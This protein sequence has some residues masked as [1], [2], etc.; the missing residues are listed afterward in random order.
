MISMTRHTGGASLCVGGES[1]GTEH[2][3]RGTHQIYNNSAWQARTEPQ[4]DRNRVTVIGDSWL[5]SVTEPD[6][7]VVIICWITAD[8]HCSW[9]ELVCRLLSFTIIYW[10]NW[11]IFRPGSRCVVF[12][13][14]VSRCGSAFQ[15]APDMWQPSARERSVASNSPH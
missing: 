13:V 15:P 12:T 9:M 10:R 4:G 2:H 6:A 5:F 1:R 8:D 3:Q 7:I 11:C 14:C